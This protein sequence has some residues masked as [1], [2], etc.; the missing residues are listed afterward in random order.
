M[1]DVIIGFEETELV[2]RPAITAYSLIVSS[3]FFMMIIDFL[4]DGHQ[5]LSGF[6]RSSVGKMLSQ[7][8]LYTVKSTNLYMYIFSPNEGV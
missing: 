8:V 3:E 7:F 2:H 1:S 5:A 6:I 4:Y